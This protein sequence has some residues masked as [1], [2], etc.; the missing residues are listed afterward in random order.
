MAAKGSRRIVVLGSMNSDF[1]MRT[2]VFPKPGET[3]RGDHFL[4]AAGGKGANQAVAAQ[5]LGASVTLLSAIGSD[6]RGEAM[7]ELLRAEGIDTSHVKR[8]PDAPSGAALILIDSSGEKSIVAAPG[9]TSALDRGYI[10]EHAE[11]IR[12]A[13]LLL[14]QFEAPMATVIAAAHTAKDAGVPVVLDPAPAVQE[15]PVELLRLLRAVRPNSH[16]A[17]ALTGVRV[18][19]RQTATEAARALKK[20]GIGY[21]AVQGGDEGNLLL[22]AEEEVW[23]P[24]MKVKAVDATGAGDAFV[25]ALSLAILEEMPPQ[26]AGAFCSAAAALATT[27]MGAQ[28]SLP[29]RAEVEQ[30]LA[31]NPT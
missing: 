19:D 3:V 2:D 21:L 18:C 12:S 15:A 24:K 28:P 23:T 27:K 10:E 4:E 9:A 22:A 17:E 30:F 25:A 1:V 20:F 16:E 13:D 14:V 6:K 29:T 5:R 8:V 31:K 7:L 11:A 26:Q